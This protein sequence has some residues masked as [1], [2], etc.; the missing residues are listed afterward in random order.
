[1]W[2]WGSQTTVPCVFYPK[3]GDGGGLAVLE[4]PMDPSDLPTSCL[5]AALYDANAQSST[6]SRACAQ[7]WIIQAR[8]YPIDK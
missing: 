5:K 6:T 2:G 8:V 3:T 7:C 1:M 4:V